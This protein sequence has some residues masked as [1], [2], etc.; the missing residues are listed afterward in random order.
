MVDDPRRHDPPEIR[1][2][3]TGV[4]VE[5]RGL[6]A[7][8]VQHRPAAAILHVYRPTLN[9]NFTAACAG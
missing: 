3:Q 9:K 7:G 8:Q 1:R 5:R 4:R 2:G 6:H